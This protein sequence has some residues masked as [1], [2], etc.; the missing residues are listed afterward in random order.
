MRK[1]AQLFS[2]S[3]IKQI[4]K[5]DYEGKSYICI[6][7]KATFSLLKGDKTDGTV[8]PWDR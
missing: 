8:S 1:Y 2:H 3:I 7:S 5:R 4:I 6:D